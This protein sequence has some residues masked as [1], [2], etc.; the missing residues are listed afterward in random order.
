MSVELLNFLS[1]VQSEVEKKPYS[2]IYFDSDTCKIEKITNKLEENETLKYIKIL[3]LNIDDIFKGKKRIEDYKVVYNLQ[4]DSYELVFLDEEIVS[5]HI[6]D[7]IYQ[8]SKV[9][10]S[11]IYSTD[12]TVRQDVREKFWHFF[13]NKSAKQAAD[14]LFFS[15]TAKNDPNILYRT[16]VIDTKS[17]KECISFPFL[18][19]IEMD[20]KKISVYTNK[21]LKTY[22][23]EVI[24]D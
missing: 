5:S 24:S 9:S 22:A 2:Y 8:I 18:Y 10:E 17:E 6:G 23:Y 12:L 16:F 13:V 20:T 1:I 15:I 19:D 11:K 4:K 21:I 14:K 3:T 7:K